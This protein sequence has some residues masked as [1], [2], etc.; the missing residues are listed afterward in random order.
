MD[1]RGF[2]ILIS[3]LGIC[4]MILFLI[5]EYNYNETKKDL[6]EIRQKLDNP[7]PIDPAVL[8]SLLE[9]QNKK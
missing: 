6:Q 3:F 9:L 4:F 8:D 2:T 5:Q 7:E 1:N